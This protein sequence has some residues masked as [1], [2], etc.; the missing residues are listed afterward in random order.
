[1]PLPSDGDLCPEL[2]PTQRRLCSCGKP[3]EVQCLSNG[4]EVFWWCPVPN[5]KRTLPI[6]QKLYWSYVKKRDE[7]AA[8][9]PAG[10]SYDESRK[11]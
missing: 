6:D 8:L 5:C 4:G 3:M 7:W 11:I 10:G 9:H 1:M 2:S